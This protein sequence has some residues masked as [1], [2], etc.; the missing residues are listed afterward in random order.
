MSDS[1]GRLLL[2]VIQVSIARALNIS[3]IRKILREQ[4]LNRHSKM[5]DYSNQEK[6]VFILNITKCTLDRCLA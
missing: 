4:A 1:D 6:Y 3:S 5:K 2:S